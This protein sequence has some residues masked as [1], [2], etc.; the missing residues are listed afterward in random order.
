MDNVFEVFNKH[1]L[2]AIGV[3][4]F[5]TIDVNKKSKTYGYITTI[6]KLDWANYNFGGDLKNRYNIPIGWTTDLNAR[7]LGELK[8]G[9]AMVVFI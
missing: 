5:S 6:P 9:A 1:K 2:E 3:G 7:T 4:S 8:N